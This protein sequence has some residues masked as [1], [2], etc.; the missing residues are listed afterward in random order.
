MVVV[1][2][3]VTMESGHGQ[4]SL[5]LSSALTFARHREANKFEL[6]ADNIDQKPISTVSEIVSVISHRQS[7]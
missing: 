6:M 4:A 3:K 1:V 2:V 7:T 5:V